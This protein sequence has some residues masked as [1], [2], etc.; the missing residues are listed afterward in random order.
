MRDAP[1]SSSGHKESLEEVLLQREEEIAILQDD[2]QQMTERINLIN[3]DHSQ[4]LGQWT[5]VCVCVCVSVELALGAVCAS[6]P[7]GLVMVTH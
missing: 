1:S 7:S 3:K 4:E 5:S 2:I 6:W